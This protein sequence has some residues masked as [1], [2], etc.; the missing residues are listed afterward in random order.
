M[1]TF[2]PLL[3][4]VLMA[5]LPV[6]AESTWTY[7]TEASDGTLYFGRNIRNYEGITFLEIKTEEDPDGKNGDKYG[8]NQ[9]FNCK[10]STWRQNNNE[11]TPINEDRVS[12]KWFTFACK[13][14]L[15]M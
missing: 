11:F 15:G 3:S 7:I 13:K 10:N 1:K 12:Y 14:K 4:F 8:W 2:I 9:A 6:I 5:P